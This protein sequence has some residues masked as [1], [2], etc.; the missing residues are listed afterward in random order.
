MRAALRAVYQILRRSRPEAF[1]ESVRDLIEE[2]ERSAFE[3]SERGFDDRASKL[4]LIAS[5]LQ[6]LAYLHVVNDLAES[7]HAACAAAA[8]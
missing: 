7:F 5:F 3:L 4:R 1:V 2:L 6:P 8:W